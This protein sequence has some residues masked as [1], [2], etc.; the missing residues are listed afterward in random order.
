MRGEILD[1]ALASF[2]QNC[3]AFLCGSNVHTARVGGVG[4]DLDQ[5]VSGEPSHHATHRRWLDLLGGGQLT[6][7]LRA[8]EDEHGK[9][10][11]ACGTFSGRDVLFADAPQKVDRSRMQAVG[12]SDGFRFRAED[13]GLRASGFGLPVVGFR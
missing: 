12:N 9:S 2:L 13:R 1:A 4:G 10:R 5:L 7:R 6:E 8:S 11:E 3:L